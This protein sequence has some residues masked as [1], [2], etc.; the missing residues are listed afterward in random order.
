M[1]TIDVFF[2]VQLTVKVTTN[3]R[4]TEKSKQTIKHGLTFPTFL[5]L[6]VSG[7]GTFSQKPSPVVENVVIGHVGRYNSNKFSNSLSHKVA[8]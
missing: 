8:I 6:L 5:L 2:L 7:S 3:K 4:M 1:V